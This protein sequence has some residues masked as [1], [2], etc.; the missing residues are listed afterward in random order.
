MA[1]CRRSV[2]S[3]YACSN[4]RNKG[5][6]DNHLTVCLDGLEEA[7]LRGLKDRLLTP[8]LTKEFV[9]EYTVEINRPKRGKQ[10]MNRELGIMSAIS[11]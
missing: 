1:A 9:R 10:R 8:E 5:T 7:V 11:V 2:V 4:R 3:H 6:C